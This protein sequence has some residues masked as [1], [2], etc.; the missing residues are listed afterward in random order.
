VSKLAVVWSVLGVEADIANV[1]TLKTTVLLHRNW[2]KQGLAGQ[3]ADPDLDGKV[4]NRLP[5]PNC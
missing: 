5:L 4:L 3:V 1:S 2:M